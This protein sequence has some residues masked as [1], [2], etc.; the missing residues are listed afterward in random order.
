MRRDTET[1]GG[2]LRYPLSDL[3]SGVVVFPLVGLY[4]F[5]LTAYLTGFSANELLFD[6]ALFAFYGAGLALVSV[7][8]LVAALAYGTAP[9]QSMGVALGI[10]VVAAAIG[11]VLAVRTP[12]RWHD[13]LRSE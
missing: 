4:V 1:F 7:P 13:R 9:L 11:G 3:L 5:G 2:A 8:L 6:T 12:A 10:S